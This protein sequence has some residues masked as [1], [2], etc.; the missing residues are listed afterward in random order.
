MKRSRSSQ[1]RLGATVV[2][3]AVVTPIFVLLVFGL[4]E[5]GRALMIKQAMT[6]AARAGSRTAILAT[7]Q[8]QDQVV[9]AARDCLASAIS[10][11]GQASVVV[12]PDDLS[13]ADRGVELTTT[14]SVSFSKLSWVVPSFL[15][16]VVI[17]SESHMTRE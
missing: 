10:D 14:V 2:E 9:A 6:D 16:D 13:S 5:F 3:M 4:I 8:S 7:T 12:T 17:K 15:G 1:C 11:P